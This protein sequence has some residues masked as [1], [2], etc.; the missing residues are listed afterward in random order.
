MSDFLKIGG[1]HVDSL[2]TETAKG[3]AV[4]AN[5]RV[6]VVRHN[7]TLMVTLVENLEKRDTTT[8]SLAGDNAVDLS[9]WTTCCMYIKNTLDVSDA[10]MQFYSQA[11]TT[12]S[13]YLRNGDNKNVTYTLKQTGAGTM[14]CT[15]DDFPI[16]NYLRYFKCGLYFPTAP[17]SGVLTITLILK[18]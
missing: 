13:R 9:E 8:I 3:I 5:G 17:T 18:R 11:E 4:D 7:E 6:E 10:Y 12:G 15:P 2:G 14:L 1:K 16:L